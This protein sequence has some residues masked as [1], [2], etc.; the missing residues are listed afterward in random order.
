M[1]GSLEN[2]SSIVSFDEVENV[3]ATVLDSLNGYVMQGSPQGQSKAEWV[4]V[5]WAEFVA[6]SNNYIATSKGS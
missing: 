4:G 6:T 3:H 2:T 1:Y 5:A